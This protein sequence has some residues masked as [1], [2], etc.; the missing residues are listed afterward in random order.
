MQLARAI[1]AED[2]RQA[3]DFCRANTDSL[4]ATCLGESAQELAKSDLEAGLALCEEISSQYP[5][6]RGRDVCF[7]NI[8]MLVA[9]T[10]PARAQQICEQMSADIEQCKQAAGK[11]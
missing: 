11:P 4:L 6:D 5:G 8:A 3:A 2:P 10:D 1:M 9:S 7:N